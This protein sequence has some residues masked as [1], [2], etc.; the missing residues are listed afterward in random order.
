M[1]LSVKFCLLIA[2]PLFRISTYPEVTFYDEPQEK[3]FISSGGHADFDN[4]VEITVPPDVLPGSIVKI[5]VQSS[6]APCYDFKLPSDLSSASPA[7]LISIEGT[8]SPD[9]E[10]TI[11]MEHHVKLTTKEEADDLVF[12][13]ADSTP[14]RKHIYEFEKVKEGRSEFTPGENKGKLT[15]KPFPGPKF[16]KI[17][18][19]GGINREK[20]GERSFKVKA[21]ASFC[22]LCV[23]LGSL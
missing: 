12:L 11:V 10:I 15:I 9:G 23:P 22:C 14:V 4:G 17:G 16:F 3:E 21:F 19:R 1:N 7:Y 8:T 20:K 18:F 5:T 2:D 13:Q 6:I